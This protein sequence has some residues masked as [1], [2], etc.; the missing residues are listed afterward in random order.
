VSQRPLAPHRW[1]VAEVDEEQRPRMVFEYVRAIEERQADI[2][3]QMYRNAYLYTG[4]ELSG[5]NVDWQRRTPGHAELPR[6]N[7]V[8]SVIE[9]A[10]SRIAALE[11]RLA[12]KT[13]GGRWDLRRRAMGAEQFLGGKMDEIHFGQEW[14]RSFR[15]AAALGTGL[16]KV[17]RDG[18]DIMCERVFPL[19]IVVDEAASRHGP[20][21]AM[22]QRRFPDVDELAAIYPEHEDEIWRSC[23]TSPEA[24]VDYIS[25][26][27]FHVPVIEAWRRATPGRPGIHGVYIEGQTLFEEAWKY[28]YHPIVEVRWQERLSGWYGIGIPEVVYFLQARVNRHASYIMACQ[29][30]AVSPVILVD[31][32]DAQLA[33]SITNDL[34]QVV[35]WSGRQAPQFV[36]PP[37]VPNEVYA[38]EERK[39]KQIY[40]MTGMSEF[41]TGSKSRPPTGLDSQPALSEWI[42]YTE[43]RFA[44]Q[45]KA[46]IDGWVTGGE[47]CLDLSRELHSD[48]KTPRATW[49]MP[50][51]GLVDVDW[52]KVALDRKSY[53]LRILPASSTSQ[54]PAGLRQR[55]EEERAAGRLPDDLYR[56]FVQTLD[57]E[58][59]YN[60]FD[61]AVSDIMRTVFLLEEED[62]PFPAPSEYQALEL[63]L[64]IVQMELNKIHGDAPPKVLR[65]LMSWLAQAEHLQTLGKGVRVGPPQ[66][67]P[68]Q[69]G[70]GAQA[71]QLA[72]MGAIPI[73]GMAS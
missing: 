45:E 50:R 9:T 67:G 2:R 52:G 11:P 65:R 34:G 24:W 36:A 25:Y 58:G 69:A 56:Y 54:Q 18:D 49:N 23:S 43:G 1:H 28:D 71:P 29:N 48:K 21:M 7:V 19:E 15:D 59:Y 26:G 10:Y 39:I 6:I 51:Y 46:Y 61:A 70:G 31:Q 4:E 12:V 30:R 32:T 17:C 3:L 22:F 33:E 62:A 27:A 73:P 42:A 40:Q 13:M 14:S 8:G 63:G 20:P 55:L 5:I 47:I 57:V 66:L 53:R 37:Q 64:W 16:T 38:D 41:S 72:D 35:P 60:L 44:R 68:G